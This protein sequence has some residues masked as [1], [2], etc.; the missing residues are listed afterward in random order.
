MNI[1]IQSV[2]ESAYSGV[3]GPLASSY[4]GDLT[5]SKNETGIRH[6][7]ICNHGST[8]LP[9]Q[10]TQE[11]MAN[12]LCTLIGYMAPFLEAL[13]GVP[14]ERGEPMYVLPPHSHPSLAQAP[15]SSSSSS[16]LVQDYR[17]QPL[18]QGGSPT[19]PKTIKRLVAALQ[20]GAGK[21]FFAPQA[22][23]RIAQ[24][25]IFFPRFAIMKKLGGCMWSITQ[26]P[27][28]CTLLRR[29]STV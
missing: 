16:R 5:N 8:T 10:E 6:A 14:L 13:R 2:R 18:A 12:L 11:E 28:K 25:S 23:R 26:G 4:D 24:M 15:P 3:W 19:K 29:S 17:Q 1:C 9:T 7:R 21:Y 22:R 27:G 20:K